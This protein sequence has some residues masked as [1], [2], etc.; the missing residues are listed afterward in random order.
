MFRFAMILIRLTTRRSDRLGQ[1]HDVVQR[2]VDAI[3]HPDPVGAR[4]DVDVGRPVAQA[5]G[6]DQLND[7][8]DGRLVVDVRRLEP[9]GVAA[10]PVADLERLDLVVDVGQRAIGGADR[11]HDVGR[12]G[13]DRD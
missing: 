6:D 4:L 1:A 9:G 11:A 13:D 7:L 2:A 3:A 12:R 5:L 8:D 10:K